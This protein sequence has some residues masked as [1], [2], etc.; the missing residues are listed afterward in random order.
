MHFKTCNVG[1][2]FCYFRTKNNHLKLKKTFGNTRIFLKQYFFPHWENNI[3]YFYFCCNH[4]SVSSY[5]RNKETTRRR[6][7]RKI[8]HSY[9]VLMSKKKIKMCW[10]QSRIIQLNW[11]HQRLKITLRVATNDETNGNRKC[12]CVATCQVMTTKLC[13][14]KWKY[15][16]IRLQVIIAEIIISLKKTVWIALC[17]TFRKLFL[18]YLILMKVIYCQFSNN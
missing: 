8:Q 4:F 6:K 5:S 14:S 16:Y 9:N 13:C 3:V 1:N 11:H 2:Y 15:I 10:R 18:M 12:F 17:Y 7:N